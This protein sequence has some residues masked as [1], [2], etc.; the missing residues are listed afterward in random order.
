MNSLLLSRS[1]FLSRSCVCRQTGC[2][3]VHRWQDRKGRI[4][5]ICAWRFLHFPTQRCDCCRTASQETKL[6]LASGFLDLLLQSSEHGACRLPHIVRPVPVCELGC[7]HFACQSS[8]AGNTAGVLQVVSQVAPEA[9]DDLGAA[10]D[11][12]TGPIRQVE[13]VDF[14]VMRLDPLCLCTCHKTFLGHD[15]RGYESY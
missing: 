10:L 7:P 5:C 12:K 11:F 13:V 8:T 4:Y 1:V 2:E 3:V 6:M 15:K 9:V 14:G